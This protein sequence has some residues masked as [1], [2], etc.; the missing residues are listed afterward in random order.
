MTTTK[1]QN[2]YKPEFKAKIAL[3]A[4]RGRLTI[5]Q[6]QRKVCGATLNFTIT[7]DRINH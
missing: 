1:K 2:V 5:N 4:V 7:K 6:N 3:G